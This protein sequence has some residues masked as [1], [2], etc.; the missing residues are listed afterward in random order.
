MGNQESVVE[1]PTTVSYDEQFI[2]TQLY[3][4]PFEQLTS[5]QQQ[6]V[7]AYKKL[8]KKY[9]QSFKGVLDLTKE[10]R[11]RLLK[12]AGLEYK[13]GRS[14]TKKVF[15]AITEYQDTITEVEDDIKDL[16]EP[17]FGT[18]IKLRQ[19]ALNKSA[20]EL[21]E[22][23]KELAELQAKLGN[24]VGQLSDRDRALCKKREE[25][26]RPYRSPLIF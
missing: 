4:M 14:K 9:E 18:L 8:G 2:A 26:L 15:Q 13:M 23:K 16:E 21:A 6:Q 20:E 10:N 3:Q 11:N 17:K 12:L 25:L 5:T 1:H 19:P 22:L 7:S 24:K